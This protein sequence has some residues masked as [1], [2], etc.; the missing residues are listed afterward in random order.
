MQLQA[1]NLIEKKE[2]KTDFQNRKRIGFKKK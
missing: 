2:H 1:I